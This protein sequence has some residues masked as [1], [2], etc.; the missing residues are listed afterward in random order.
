M[1]TLKNYLKTNSTNLLLAGIPIITL[2]SYI[3][4]QKSLNQCQKK[5]IKN[6]N[7]IR[8]NEIYNLKRRYKEQ[9]KEYERR[10]MELNIKLQLLTS[11]YNS[12]FHEQVTPRN[13]N[14]LRFKAP[15]DLINIQP[16]VESIEESKEKM[17]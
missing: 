11:D 15:L 16:K 10:V 3:F 13:P 14:S 17:S 5:H 2:G 7:D 1:D 4:F 6:I 12:L 8:K 9:I